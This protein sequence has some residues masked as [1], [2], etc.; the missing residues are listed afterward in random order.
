[1][2]FELKMLQIVIMAGQIQVDMMRR[3]R[4]SRYAIDFGLLRCLPLLYK[5]VMCRN[6]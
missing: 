5:G 2:A 4:E 3:S 6:R 1:M